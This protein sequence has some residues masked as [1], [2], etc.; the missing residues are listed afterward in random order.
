MKIKMLRNFDE[1]LIQLL[2][3]VDDDGHHL[4]FAGDLREGGAIMFMVACF[5]LSQASTSRPK[6]HKEVSQVNPFVFSFLNRFELEKQEK[7]RKVQT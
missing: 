4:A 5:K 3:V 2:L 6:Y 7:G 1:F